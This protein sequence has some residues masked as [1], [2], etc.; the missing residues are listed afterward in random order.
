MVELRQ[1]QGAVLLP[2]KVVPG[3][4]RTRLMGELDGRVKIAVASPPEGGKA[5]QALIS[6]LAGV[7]DVKKKALTV[8]TG[9]TS[10]TK[11][12]RIDRAQPDDVR[13]A[14]GLDRS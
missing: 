7:L 3:A 11:T 10:P 4:S 14:L 12:I 6:F 13:R 5:N 2:V 9:R 8:E 1:D